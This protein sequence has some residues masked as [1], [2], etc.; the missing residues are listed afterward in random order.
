MPETELISMKYLPDDYFKPEEP[1]QSSASKTFGFLF[2][3]VLIVGVVGSSWWFYE[4]KDQVLANI[5]D[6]SENYEHL[7]QSLQHTVDPEDI[8]EIDV[9]QPITN[10]SFAPPLDNSFPNN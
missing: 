7:F 9:E 5:R 8:K 6:N 10:A 4:N 1:P 2:R 3:V